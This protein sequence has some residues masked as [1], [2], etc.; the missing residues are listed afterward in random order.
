MIRRYLKLLLVLILV[1]LVM[2]CTI[3][4]ENLP[5][6]YVSLRDTYENN[7]L[8]LQWIVENRSH[9]DVVPITFSNGK[10]LNYNIRHHGSGIT[11]TNDS[12]TESDITLD[13][14]ERYDTTVQFKDLPSGHYSAKF[15]A[16][17]DEDHSFTMIINFD[18]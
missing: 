8:Y 9:C 14:G 4:T 1:I 18:I 11:Y 13:V 10:I 2:G 17:Y 15:W 12:K 5:L 7:I 3:N 6:V 16:E